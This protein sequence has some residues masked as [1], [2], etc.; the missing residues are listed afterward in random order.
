[1]IFKGP[2]PW[3]IYISE[4]IPQRPVL[5]LKGKNLMEKQQALG[6]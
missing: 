4:K 5:N 1:M 3:N 6:P 2:D